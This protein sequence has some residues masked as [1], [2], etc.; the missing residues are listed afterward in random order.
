[1]VCPIKDAN[2]H[3]VNNK[4][5]KAA[6][7]AVALF[8][9]TDAF[10]KWYGS[11]SIPMVVDG[12]YI[13]NSKG[14]LITVSSIID[15]Y[16][17]SVGKEK[18]APKAPTRT[19][20]SVNNVIGQTFEQVILH[21]KSVK[22]SYAKDSPEAKFIDA[23]DSNSSLFKGATIKLLNDSG[24]AAY[25]DSEENAIYVYSGL[26]EKADDALLNRVLLHELVH[27]TTMAPFTK[28]ANFISTR[29]INIRSL[30]DTEVVEMALANKVITEKEAKFVL[31]STALWAKATLTSKKFEAA[32]NLYGLK[33]TKEFVAEMMSNPQFYKF[34]RDNEES[35][36]IRFWKNVLQLFGI[37]MDIDTPSFDSFMTQILEQT[38][39]SMKEGFVKNIV[40][41]DNRSYIKLDEVSNKFSD[42][43]LAVD[44]SHYLDGAR[45]PYDRLTNWIKKTFSANPSDLGDAIYEKKAEEIYRSLGVDKANTIKIKNFLGAEETYTFQQLVDKQKIDQ[46]TAIAYG[47]IAHLM[48][49]RA[50]RIA[51]SLPIDG[52]NAKIEELRK[53]KP[54]Q[55]AIDLSRM[56]WLGNI[57]VLGPLFRR[58]GLNFT[59]QTLANEAI[60]DKMK[61]E[62]PVASK[63]LG[64]ATKIDMLVQHAD[65]A[66]SIFD[67]KTGNS[68]FKDEMTTLIMKYSSG[69]FQ[70]NDSRIN[71]SKLE[72][73]LRAMMIKESFPDVKFREMAVVHLDKQGADR[74][75]QADFEVFL[76]MVEAFVKAERPAVYQEMVDKGLFNPRAY[77]SSSR[78]AIELDAATEG[79]KSTEEQLQYAEQA[80]MS[81]T[82][83]RDLSTLGVDSDTKQTAAD[84]TLAVLE[85]QSGKPISPSAD[86]S[87]MGT[88]K[89]WI[90]NIYSTGNPLVQSFIQYFTKAKDKA[91]EEIDKL[92]AEEEEKLQAVM[93]EYYDQHP[94]AKF[95]N[96]IVSGITWHKE[97]GSGVFDF[98]W[99]FVESIDEPGWYTRVITEKDVEQGRFTKAQYEYNKF[100][101]ENIQKYYKEVMGAPVLGTKSRAELEN[102]PISLP[103]NFAPR[104]FITRDDIIERHGVMSRK[105]VDYQSKR[106]LSTFM[107]SELYGKK[108]NVALPLKYIGNP[109]II[110]SQNHTFNSQSSF[111]LFMTNLI[112]KKHLDPAYS[113][114]QGVKGVLDLQGARAHSDP[115]YYKTTRDFVNDLIKAQI[116]NIDNQVSYTRKDIKIGN[117]TLN[118]SK[119]LDLLRNFVSSST[120]WLQ[121]WAG[122]FNTLLIMTLN[123]KAAIVG[124]LGKNAYKDFGASDLAFGMK[125]W[126]TSIAKGDKSK[127]MAIAKSLRYLPNNYDYA[128][129]SSK[130][131]SS[132]HTMVSKD[133]FYIFHS[134]GEDMGQLSLMAAMLHY[135]KNPKTGK[136][137]WEEYDDNGVWQG[138][139][140]GV[141][142]AGE[143]ITG[144]TSEEVTSM[145]RV[146]QKIHGGYRDSE[147]TALE[148]SALG[149]WALQFKKYL[150][151][152]FES[153]WTT[154]Y[155]DASQ[156]EWVKREPVEGTLFDKA[157]NPVFKEITLEDGTVVK[158]DIYEWH[159]RLQEGRV[160]TIVGIIMQLV[161]MKNDPNYS[162]GSLGSLQKK[163]LT[164]LA[165]AAGFMTL[166]FLGMA[167]AFDDDD[168]DSKIYRKFARYREDIS[169][170]MHPMD[171]IRSVQQPFVALTKFKQ[172]LEAFGTFMVE[173]VIQD[174]RTQ[175]GRYPGAAQLMK[176]FPITSSIENLKAYGEDYFEMSL[177]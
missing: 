5:G 19:A 82:A 2:W 170:G 121:P 87:P 159:A 158:E 45:T 113:V 38:Q 120:M 107:E 155:T 164:D 41:D 77:K 104:A 167:S 108:D 42:I 49:E 156:G 16:T 137:M 50:I 69:Y 10:Q 130:M 51:T 29:N 146:S 60:R 34:L 66:V 175:E 58:L 110:G 88:V 153:V 134:I 39:S 126:T 18:T 168:E 55:N 152:I 78:P 84:L 8:F 174:K 81:L 98:M 176:T 127:L 111:R 128:A 138:G 74:I 119:S 96:K 22:D 48:I 71:K 142:E 68:F 7:N 163:N 30:S 97:D 59:D 72:I 57:A 93:D 61:S 140:R 56:Q 125:E 47:N 143:V 166:V 23:L 112:M 28:V 100:Q 35:I 20:T 109:S 106:Y 13:Y 160:N 105:M 44:E 129:H 24:T 25:Y 173:G 52:I 46:N 157:G 133:K 136:S 80:L 114:G 83:S 9:G 63:L 135:Q 70:A 86:A 124:S 123:T 12:E 165:V 37:K 172:S 65:E 89:R 144:L 40:P 103:A 4:H 151:A 91:Y 15:K 32:K 102:K 79:A 117:R 95:K 85:K 99:E 33:D 131:L 6:A 149:R 67:W 90:G 94:G 150:P 154:A 141:S 75:L 26:L 3:T 54:D 148:M 36:F 162:L 132:K 27:V 122:A 1:M 171:L 139:V 53:A 76:P 62:V 177:H 73:I 115:D 145:K 31:T 64:V 118:I 21:F 92:F 14:E 101:R 43:V 161:G 169:Q 147:R 17:Q 116:Q 11:T